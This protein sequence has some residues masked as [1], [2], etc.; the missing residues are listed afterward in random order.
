MGLYERLAGTEGPKL[1]IHQFVGAIGEWSRG[2]ITSSD[3]QNSF[4]LSAAELVEANTLMNKLIVPEHYTS[5]GGFNTLTN[6]GTAYDTTSASKG[7]GMIRVNFKGIDVIRFDIAYSK[8]STATL[9]WQLWNQ[10]DGV[11]IGVFTDSDV[12]LGDRVNGVTINSNLPTDIK[13]V[14]V[15]VKSSVATDDPLYY[16]ASLAMRYG[17]SQLHS[18]QIHEVLSMAEYPCFPYDTV[19]AVKNRFGV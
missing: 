16:G 5:L 11:Q 4:G 10:T 17:I 12:A 14:R 3:L 18:W 13:L 19:T 9:D 6:V 2:L 8:V 15:R 1:P 7:L